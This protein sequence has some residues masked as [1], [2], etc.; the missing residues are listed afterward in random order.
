MGASSRTYARL[1]GG[2]VSRASAGSGLGAQWGWVE[3]GGSV[4]EGSKMDG[5]LILSR[6][7]RGLGYF[8]L[9]STRTR[10]GRGGRA[11]IP[12][13]HGPFRTSLPQAQG[14]LQEPEPGSVSRQGSPPGRALSPMRVVRGIHRPSWGWH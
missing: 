14:R 1:A 13:T 4:G 3:V 9:L 6:D 5:S 2:W 8:P 12:L 11:L 7:E 10:A